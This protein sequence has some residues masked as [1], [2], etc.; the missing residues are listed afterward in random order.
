MKTLY[1]HIGT[2]KT[3]TTAIQSFCYDNKDVLEQQGYYYPMFEY[4]FENVQ[5]YRNGHFLVCRVFDESHTR[6]P[7]K[8]E[9]LTM[10]ILGELLSMFEQHETIILSDEGIWN[11][12]FFED[13]HCWSKIRKVLIDNGIL[14]KVIV[15]FRRQDDFLFSW[16]NQQ[17]KE[18]MHPSSVMDWKEITEKLPYIKLDY[19]G[20]LE[21]IAEYV[22]KDNILVRL[23]DRR[24]FVGGTIQEDFLDAI[25]LSLTEDFKINDTLSNLSLTK[26]DIE[27][28]R[29]LNTLSGLDKKE[30]ALFRKVLSQLSE[31]SID[32]RS[33][34]MFSTEEDMAFMQQ[35]AEGNDK[36]AKE[37]MHRD[38]PMFQPAKNSQQKWSANNEQM[39]E[40]VVRF[41]GTITLQL[42]R[43][44][45]ELKAELKTQKQHINN[46]R[47]KMQH[48]AK[49]II[50][51]IRRT[52]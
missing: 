10:Q 28:K 52:E 16:W 31:E 47:F 11:R 43:E 18:G 46:I 49:A 3:A 26:N 44:N 33:V 7:E 41:F 19:Y 37:Y 51:K 25:G 36:I 23:F 29:A 20:Y 32:D 22:G 30:N 1:L 15:Y 4:Q 9:S 34:S 40:D 42:L 39:V 6:L 5:K 48:P 8:Q 24:E 27:I 38:A 35:F 50:N 21:Q 13:T 14:V 45:E 17:I 2:P 12:G